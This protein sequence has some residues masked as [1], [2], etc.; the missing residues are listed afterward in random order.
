VCVCV[1]VCICVRVN[2]SCNITVSNIFRAFSLN[3]WWK[4]HGFANAPPHTFGAATKEQLLQLYLQ[5]LS[6]RQQIDPWT[7]HVQTCSDCRAALR[8]WKSVQKWSLGA[9]IISAALV[10]PSS[11]IVAAAFG[12]TSFSLHYFSK[13]VATTMEGNPSPAG[14]DDRS[15]ATK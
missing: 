5:P 7:N 14:I 10:G 1:C 12:I 9:T 11:P 13:A 2:L 15:V 6:R 4:Q 8:N 3:K